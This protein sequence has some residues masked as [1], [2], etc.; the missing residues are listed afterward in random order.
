MTRIASAGFLAAGQPE[1]FLYFPGVNDLLFRLIRK[2]KQKSLQIILTAVLYT[3]AILLGN[4]IDAAGMVYRA[5]NLLPIILSVI[6]RGW[7]VC[8]SSSA[9]A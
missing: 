6:T 7:F 3:A 5:E 2:L 9:P 4:R 1:G 8:V